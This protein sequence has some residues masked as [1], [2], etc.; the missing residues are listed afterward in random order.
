MERAEGLEVDRVYLNAAGDAY[1]A[2]ARDLIAENTA[3]KARLAHLDPG[4][5]GQRAADAAAPRDGARGSRGGDHARGRRGGTDKDKD[6]AELNRLWH[7][8]FALS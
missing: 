1:M 8:S 6:R 5:G 4:A 3:L 7:Q 2:E